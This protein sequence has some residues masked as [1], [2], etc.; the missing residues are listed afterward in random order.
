MDKTNY[1]QAIQ[2]FLEKTDNEKFLRQIYTIWKL[3]IK[4]TEGEN[5]EYI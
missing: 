1:K 5:H 2:A 4:R 3:H